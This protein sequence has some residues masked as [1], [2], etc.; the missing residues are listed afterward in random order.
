VIETAQRINSVQGVLLRSERANLNERTV[1]FRLKANAKSNVA[2]Q[3]LND[4]NLFISICFQQTRQGLIDCLSLVFQKS[5]NHLSL[6][7]LAKKGVAAPT[8]LLAPRTSRSPHTLRSAYW[9]IESPREIL[10]LSV[11]V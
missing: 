5:S 11:R 1:Y 8:R 7:G 9:L 4:I 2:P 10:P 6:V 3:L